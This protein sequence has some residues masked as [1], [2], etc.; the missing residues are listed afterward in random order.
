MARLPSDS[1]ARS[2]TWKFAPLHCGLLLYEAPARTGDCDV[3]RYR[4]LSAAAGVPHQIRLHAHRRR[5]WGDRGTHQPTRWDDQVS[6]RTRDSVP[7]GFRSSYWFRLIPGGTGSDVAG[8]RVAAGF[9]EEGRKVARPHA[10]R[11]PVCQHEIAHFQSSD[12]PET[13]R[14]WALSVITG[15]LPHGL[16]EMKT[17]PAV[18][19]WSGIIDSGSEARDAARTQRRRAET[20]RRC[21]RLPA[22]YEILMMKLRCHVMR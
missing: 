12:M 4:L 17:T 13:G 21:C 20:S 14:S 6:V 7:E 1:G 18:C 19:T 10:H 16:R 3:P 22:P 5:C 9:S 11:P 15:H 2:G 8:S